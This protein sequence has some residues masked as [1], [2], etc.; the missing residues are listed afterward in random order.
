MKWNGGWTMLLISEAL[1]PL[2]G[3]ATSIFNKKIDIDLVFIPFFETIDTHPVIEVILSKES[4]KKFIEICRCLLIPCILTQEALF[5]YLFLLHFRI[6]MKRHHP[7]CLNEHRSFKYFKLN[8]TFNWNGN[9]KL[10][11]NKRSNL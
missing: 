11:W 8:F 2:F 3:L 1:M 6:I 4:K 10:K 7:L 5:R 9:D